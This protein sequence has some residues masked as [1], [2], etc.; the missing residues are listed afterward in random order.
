MAL[1]QAVFTFIFND[2]GK[3][4]G[5]QGCWRIRGRL[6]AEEYG[7]GISAHGFD[8]SGAVGYLVELGRVHG[9]LLNALEAEAGLAQGMTDGG[10]VGCAA[11]LKGHID[12]RFSQADAVVGAV[13]NGLDDIGALAGQGLGQVK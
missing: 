3:M 11:G 4:S 1:D 6:R 8:E 5:Y 7:K 12:H 2:Q 13:V 9:L 10:N